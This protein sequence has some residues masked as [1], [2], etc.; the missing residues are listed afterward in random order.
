MTRTS[1]RGVFIK[2][3][4]NYI[5]GKHKILDQILPLFPKDINRFVDLFAGGCNVAINVKAKK[6]IANDNLTYLIELYEAFGKY[7]SNEVLK[8]I[9]SRIDTYDLSLTND[10]GY[11]KMRDLY[12]KE[13]N[14]LDLF[15][16]TAYSF[17]H[18]IRFNNNHQFNNP[19]GRERS[20]FNP[21][22]ENNLDKF[23]SKVHEANL[24]FSAL[25]FDEFDF[26]SLGQNDFV[27]CDPPYLITTGSY[28]DG[29]RG[30]TGWNKNEE[31]KLLSILDNLD[32][33]GIKFAL[34]NVLVHKG[35]Q[36]DILSSWIEE[37]NYTINDISK[38]Y[39]N[40]SYH[41]NN[42]DRTATREV[43]VTNYSN[44]PIPR[45]KPF[46]AEPQDGVVQI[47]L[48]NLRSEGMA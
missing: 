29:K 43:V 46:V 31:I 27:Y 30:F 24:E 38:D 22:M 14:P 35:N 48:F 15:V 44:T 37:N 17:N 45:S 39:A 3:P 28:N 36:N 4:M 20:S 7:S 41:T 34:S 18:Q 33:R 19:F 47:P 12:N 6:V 1:S 21:A 23:V 26:S 5:G 13:R 11:K 8:H 42:R 40:S 9:R 16:L 10:D 25:N 2:S 32:S